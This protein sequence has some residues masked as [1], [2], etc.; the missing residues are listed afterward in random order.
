MHSVCLLAKR[1]H[2]Q[3]QLDR[4]THFL[5]NDTPVLRRCFSANKMTVP[6]NFWRDA[7]S[8]GS[9]IEASLYHFEQKQYDISLALAC[10]AVDATA[11]KC[12]YE[13]SNNTKYKQFLKENM[14]MITT[15]GFPGIS[16]SGIKIKCVN[17]TGFKTD[18][19][20]RVDIENIIYHTIRCGLIHQCDIDSQIEFT[21][22]TFIGDFINKFK[23]P[24]NLVIGLIVAVV[25]AKCNQNEQL[26]ED[27][28]IT[29][30]LTKKK[31]N[32]NKIWGDI[33]VG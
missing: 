18:N 25:R 13:G 1:E 11:S 10:S 22:D 6:S 28:L 5:Y 19:N 26:C 29:N 31:I 3:A 12:G 2:G 24:R 15:F 7:M 23:M 8:I 33:W 16:A 20:N 17:I 4:A 14:R 30:P 21:P 32:L 27:Y 9:F